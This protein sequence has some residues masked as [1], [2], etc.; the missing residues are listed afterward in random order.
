MASALELAR[1]GSLERPKPGPLEQLKAEV[2]G[3]PKARRPTLPLDKTS[4]KRERHR[5]SSLRKAKQDS[6]V[7]RPRRQS[8]LIGYE[9]KYPVSVAVDCVGA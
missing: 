2:D 3:S 9:A 4:P 5:P 6:P 7:G 8:S 1:S